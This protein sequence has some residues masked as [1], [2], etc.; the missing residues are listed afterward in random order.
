M[1]WRAIDRQFGCFNFDTLY[2][3]EGYLWCVDWLARW[4]SSLATE[5]S[6]IALT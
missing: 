6:S 1:T 3:E 4:L 2:S 5:L